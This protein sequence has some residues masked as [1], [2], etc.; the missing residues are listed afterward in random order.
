[1]TVPPRAVPGEVGGAD[2][3]VIRGQLGRR[4]QPMS[5]VVARCPYGYPAAVEDLPYDAAGRPFPTLFYCT[6]PTLV[7][8]VSSL[9]S[10]GGVRAWSDCAARD[11][12]LGASL[13][14]ETRYTRRRRRALARRHG[15]PM[16]DDGAS[17]AGGIGG[18]RAGRGLKCLHAHAAHAL[19]RPGYALG[20]AV[21][22]AAGDPWCADRRCAGFDP[23]SEAPS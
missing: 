1:M 18:V 23:R 13:A 12:A 19:A 4:P 17:L 15:L 11:P 21:L 22:A 20:T 3:A 5:R 16:L 10:A 9:E 8:A 14:A 7:A 2:L 6:C